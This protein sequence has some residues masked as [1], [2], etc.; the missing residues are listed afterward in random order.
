MRPEADMMNKL[1]AFMFND[2]GIAAI[3][4]AVIGSFMGLAL[5]P[6]LPGVSE[7]VESRLTELAAFF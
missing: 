2:K 4:Y 3:E 6:L 5:L 7:A 1:A